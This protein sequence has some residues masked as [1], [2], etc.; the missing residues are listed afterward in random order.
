MQIEPRQKSLSSIYIYPIKSTAGFSP[1]QSFVQPEGLA[2]DRRWAVIDQENRILT[3]REHPALLTIH[4]SIAPD[5][6]LIAVPGFPPLEVP[7][8]PHSKNLL[9][10]T[11]FGL[12]VYG[13]HISQAD[14]L[15]SAHLGRAA[16]LIF[17]DDDCIRY[18]LPKHGGG[19]ADRVSYAD[20]APLLL[21]TAATLEALNAR[22]PEKVSMRNF[23]SN[24]VI[25]GCVAEEE[26]GWKEIRIGEV[27]FEVSEACKRC[28]VT[29]LD[30]VTL[31]RYLH[32][33]PLRTLALYKKHPRGGVSFGINLIPRSK[34]VIRQGDLVKI[35]KT[36]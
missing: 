21:T 13:N 6:L 31:E 35:V 23:R 5:A 20:S 22:L 2:Y 9:P 29:T 28:M 3:P 36:I 27:L 30:P 17:M 7:L 10:V 16:R 19:S 1:V 25:D 24:L 18:M 11:V 15:L 8:I 4:T 12:P 34:G 14:A 26:E 32:Q 33:E